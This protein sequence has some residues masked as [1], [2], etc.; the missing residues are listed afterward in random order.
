MA[1]TDYGGNAGVGVA[2]GHWGSANDTADTIN[3]PNLDR[4]GLTFL[5]SEIGFRNIADGTSN[6]M[7][8]GEKYL[9]P[10]SYF[11]SDDPADNTS[12]FAGH[13][14]DILRWTSQGDPK[15]QETWVSF[16]PLQDRPGVQRIQHFGSSHPAG[17]NFVFCD[18]SVHGLSYSIDSVTWIRIGIRDDEL[19]IDSEQF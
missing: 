1:H 4:R 16:P 17:A 9:N 15:A 8:V 6:T 10:D 14:W 5:R 2:V 12:M 3:F 11:K 19:P 18:G 13:D 7:Y